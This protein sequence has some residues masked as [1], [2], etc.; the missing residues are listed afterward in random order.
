MKRVRSFQED[1]RAIENHRLCRQCE[2][3]LAGRRRAYCSEECRV[4]W[5][6]PRVWTVAVREVEKRDNGVCA[7]CG[8]DA[9]EI[10]KTFLSIKARAWSN[11]PDVRKQAEAERRALIAELNAQGFS[12]YSYTSVPMWGEL[13][14]VDHITP[15]AEGGGGCGLSNLQ[16][17]C[18]SCHKAKTA[19]QASRK[20]TRRKPQKSLDLDVP[21]VPAGG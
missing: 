5:L 19:E 14:Q 7:A 18:T 1:V 8:R 11:D 12:L 6:V 16:T 4:A 10:V 20:A 15:V 3:P 21:E 17:L 2:K 9:V 13:Y